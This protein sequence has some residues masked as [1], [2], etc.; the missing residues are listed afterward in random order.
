MRKRS[1]SWG[2]IAGS[3]WAGSQDGEYPFAVGCAAAQSE[4]LAPGM[5]RAHGGVVEQGLHDG[6]QAETHLVEFSQPLG[7]ERP[8]ALHPFSQQSQDIKGDLG[9]GKD[10]GVGGELGR[11]EAFQPDVGFEFGMELL[12]GGV[13]VVEIEHFP[14]SRQ[15]RERLRKR[16]GEFFS[17]SSWACT[18]ACGCLR[19]GASLRQP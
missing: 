17:R 10:V 19:S 14:V 13:G 9:A 16:V 12:A 2:T 1:S 18:S 5:M 7:K 15:G 4:Q 3:A 6:A 8:V 11:G